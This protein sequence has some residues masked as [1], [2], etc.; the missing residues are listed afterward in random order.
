MI[1]SRNTQP[2]S[3]EQAMAQQA[4]ALEREI[5]ADPRQKQ[6]EIARRALAE[7]EAVRKGEAPPA[8]KPVKFRVATSLPQA[9]QFVLEDE[10]RP[11]TPADMLPLISRYGITVGTDKPTW[12]VSN[13]M[14][15]KKAVFYRIEWGG[16][17][18]WWLT[19]QPIPDR[20]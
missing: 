10:K 9:A 1:E 14:S 15:A 19:G 5:A 4:E 16:T 13:A 6:L 3:L 18:C 2:T 11:M 8:P 17:W 20:N 7:M 12:A